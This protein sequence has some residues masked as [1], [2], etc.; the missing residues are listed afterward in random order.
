MENVHQKVI[1]TNCKFIQ[2]SKFSLNDIWIRYIENKPWVT[3]GIFA[4]LTLT[5]QNMVPHAMHILDQDLAANP[6]EN[7]ILY[8]FKQHGKCFGIEEFILFLDDKDENEVRRFLPGFGI[9]VF[10][11]DND[12]VASCLCLLHSYLYQMGYGCEW[13]YF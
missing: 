8:G 2:C 9:K 13:Q 1:I 4:S 3:T 12:A 6:E 5:I 11:H 10:N 7:E